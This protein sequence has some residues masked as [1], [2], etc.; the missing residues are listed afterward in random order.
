MLGHVRSSTPNWMGLTRGTDIAKLLF[1]RRILR[2][3]PRIEI[4]HC[5]RCHARRLFLPFYQIGSLRQSNVLRLLCFSRRSSG[6]AGCLGGRI[7]LSY[8]LL[9]R[10]LRRITSGTCVSCFGGFRLACD[11][12]MSFR[13]ACVIKCELM[14]RDPYFVR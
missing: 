2:F 1:K 9:G 12:D 13:Q 4:F 3:R 7:L 10:L 5:F 6:V 11:H 14:A 8:R